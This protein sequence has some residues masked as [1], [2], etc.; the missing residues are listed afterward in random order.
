MID[1]L[2]FIDDRYETFFRPF[3]SIFGNFLF[4]FVEMVLDRCR[5]YKSV[6]TKNWHTFLNLTVD[7]LDFLNNFFHFWIFERT[8]FLKYQSVR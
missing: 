4:L 1:F 7:F 8:V 5:D 6:Q 3:G 2:T